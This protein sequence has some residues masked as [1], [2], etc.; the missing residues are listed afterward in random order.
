M[1]IFQDDEI[2]WSDENIYYAT[3]L[4]NLV[5]NIHSSTCADSIASASNTHD[6]P[7]IQSSDSEEA[8]SLADIQR[9]QRL[10]LPVK[11]KLI[12]QNGKDTDDSFQDKTY[13]PRKEDIT[14]SESENESLLE[15][16]TTRKLRFQREK[17]WKKIPKHTKIK[18]MNIQIK[19]TTI[20]QLF[21]YNLT[22]YS[23][24][25]KQ[26]VCHLLDE[27]QCERGFYEIHVATC[28]MKN[29]MSVCLQ[30]NVRDIVNIFDTCSWQNRNH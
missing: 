20:V 2:T 22:F 7:A 5:G 27:T 16:T 10:R 4:V 11:R 28:L 26:V 18:Q 25:D 23:L 6:E 8:I 21:C 19:V 14:S 12:N 29:T 3:P 30:S 17:A 24:R 9:R 15:T 13:T 1:I